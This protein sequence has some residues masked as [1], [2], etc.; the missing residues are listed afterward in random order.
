MIGECVLF[1]VKMLFILLLPSNLAL[2][3]SI[4]GTALVCTRKIR[5]GRAL[6]AVSMTIL[7]LMGIGPVPQIMMR[8]LENRF[9][10]QADGGAPIDGLIV[11]GGGLGVSR[12][13][14]RL[15]DAGSR[16]AAA[17]TLALKNP[18]SKIIFTGRLDGLESSTEMEGASVLGLLGIARERIVIQKESSNTRE[19]ALF[20]LPLVRRKPGERWLLITS[21]FHMPRAIATFRAVGLELE[22]F[23]VDFRTEGNSADFLPFTSLQ[24]GLAWADLATREWAA[25]TIYRLLGYSRD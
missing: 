13:Q 22:P 7:V 5:S 19:D 23:P 18:E 14:L 1:W 3:M 16:I 11:L 4:V 9:S 25:L 15:T 8:S 12:G 17:I 10:D 2:I 20:T 21:A 24:N 6:L